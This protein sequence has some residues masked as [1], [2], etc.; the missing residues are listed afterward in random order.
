MAREGLRNK[1]KAAIEQASQQNARTVLT[2]A[3]MKRDA[4]AVAVTI[5]VQPAQSEGR[6]L[7]LVSFLDEP[8]R[9]TKPGRSG[10]RADVSRVTEL[11]LELDATSK[12]LQ[13][14]LRDLELSSEEQRA[15]NAEASSINEEYQSANEELETSKEELQSLNEELTALNSQLQET[16]ERQRSTSNDLQNILYSADSATLFLDAKLRIRFFTPAAKSF[17]RIIASDIGRPLADLAPLAV[18]ATLLADAGAVLTGVVPSRHEIDAG[19]D[20]WYIRRVLP[21]RGHDDRIEGVVITFAD[22]SLVKAAERRIDAARVYSDSVINTVRQ[23]LLVLDGALRVVS[24]NDAF[25]RTFALA[26]KLAVGRHFAAAGAHLAEIAGLRSFLERVRVEPAPV[27]D[28]EVEA[29]LPLLG[30]RVLQMTARPIRDDLAGEAKI[31]LAIDDITER[32]RVAETLES[33]KRQA[34]QANLAKSRFLAA[35]SHDLR[36]P[37]QTLSLLQGIL[38][39]KVRDPDSLK[40]VTRLEETLGAM[41]GML[42]TLLDIN[43]LEAGTVRPELVTFPIE[44]LLERL[45]SEFAYHAAARSLGWRMVPC[46]LSV[47]SD[48]RL[49]EQMIRNLLSNAAKY[50]EHGG[51][52]LGCRRRGDKLRIEVWDT[53]RGIPEGQLRSI[54]EEFR[55]LDNSARERNRGLGLGL[56][57]VQRLA[58]LLGHAVDVRSRPGKGSVFAVEVPIGRQDALQPQ[59]LG[60]DEAAARVG[61]GGTILVVEDDPDV[62]EMLELLLNDEGYATVAAADG[63][64]ALE[65]AA[66]GVPRLDLV[67]ADYNLPNGPSGLQVCAKLREMLHQEIPVIILTGDISTQTLREIARHGCP[68]LNKPVKVQ[69]LTNLIRHLLLAPQPTVAPRAKPS[70][71]AGNGARGPIIFVVDDDGALRQSMRDLL[72]EDGRSVEVYAG[73]EAFL[74]AY[75]PGTDGC[76]L[77]DAVMPGMSGF[78]LLQ[79]LKDDGHRLPAIMITGNGDVQM[80]VRAMQAGAVDFIEKPV[81]ATEL[82]ASIDHALEQTRDAAKG[83]ARREAAATCLAGLTSRQRQILGLVLA[84]HPS[85]NIAA[86]LHISQR[87]VENHRAAIMHRTGSKSVPAL[88]RFALATSEE[89]V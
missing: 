89:T 10:E 61:S 5:A 84:G 20:T 39:K 23:P 82:L 59:A 18:D 52:L 44:D 46:G 53:G 72:G 36:Q 11:E 4:V 22:I 75:R 79:R 71:G 16:L 55:Q 51:V 27:A 37:L 32:R 42:N 47:H 35:A 31:L 34:E 24:G 9:A 86:D 12:E 29:E 58:D 8:A 33:A 74:E 63:K 78:A 54:F 30:R 57:I 81:G 45:R 3:R 26:P 48:P 17:F 80:A 50:T 88:V 2:G 21:Y 68:Q 56:A 43:Q 64:R 1:L 7:L 49:L 62:R 73:G 65:L 87:T 14:A 13:S 85:K 40:L 28:V 41:S 15:I 38:S 76:L 67:V 70:L 77:V 83:F 66:L 60:R 6:A 19:A 25:Y 69:E